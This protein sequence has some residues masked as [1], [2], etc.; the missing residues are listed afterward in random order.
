MKTNGA[1]RKQNSTIW[2]QTVLYVNKI[3]LYENKIALYENKIALYE[4]NQ[5]KQRVTCNTKID[6]KYSAMLWT[7]TVTLT[8]KQKSNLVT[9][10]CTYIHYH[11]TKHGCKKD[12][13]FRSHSKNSHSDNKHEPSLWPWPWRGTAVSSHDNTYLAHNI[14]QRNKLG[15]IR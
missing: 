3:A 12:Q 14:H 9:K 15:Y 5:Q 6:D 2:K 11:Q 10:W 13:Q 4:N 1:I 7:F 8:L